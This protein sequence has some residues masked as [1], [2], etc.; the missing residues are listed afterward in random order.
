[1][2][3]LPSWTQWRPALSS[4][5]PRTSQRAQKRFSV[6]CL[7]LCRTTIASRRRIKLLCKGLR[8]SRSSSAARHQLHRN[9]SNSS[10]S[11]SSSSNSSNSSSSS[12]SNSNRQ[13]E[14]QQW[15]RLLLTFCLQL[16]LLELPQ[17]PLRLMFPLLCSSQLHCMRCRAQ[18]SM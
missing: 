16:R 5:F 4:N 6:S 8:R 13:L 1:M 7:L 2:L 11:S 17:C 14:L 18:K 10:N 3:L 9:S 15:L 12:N